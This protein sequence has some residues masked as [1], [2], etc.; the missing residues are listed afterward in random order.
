[1]NFKYMVSQIGAFLWENRSNIEFVVGTGLVIGGT[2]VI[3]SKAEEA[4]EVKREM[5]FKIKEIE[6]AD[7]SDG[8]ENPSDRTKACFKMAKDTAIGY[9]KAYGLGIGMEVG[10]MVLQG[11]SK[12]TDRRE[13]AAKAT[14][15]SCLAAQFAAYRQNVIDEQG[16]E[17]DERYLLG[18]PEVEVVT[19]ENGEH[20]V[21]EKVT[22]I[23]DHS[24]L[25]DETNDHFEK[26]GFMNYDF[27]DDHERWLNEKLYTR[28]YLTENEIREEVDAPISIA[29]ADGDWGITAFDDEGNRNYISFG[30]N[31]NTERAKKF[32]DG[33]EKSFLVI[34]TNM[35]PNIH[36]KLYRLNKYHKD[37][38]IAEKI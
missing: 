16:E 3:I 8:W 27:L 6:L 11:I 1:M 28:G 14:A 30:I 34:L 4:V 12:V 15:L 36:R 38:Q 10:G 20:A 32:R 19:N 29:A 5:E 26:E 2:C 7:E 33:T 21:K 9:T 24:F 23:P 25:F 35:E 37:V 22:S 17:A 18:K 13:I 31:K